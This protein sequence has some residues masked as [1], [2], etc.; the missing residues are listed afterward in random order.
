MIV[1]VFLLFM[2]MAFLSMVSSGQSAQDKEA[3]KK[4]VLAFQDDFNDGQ[5][6]MALAYTTKDWKHINPLGGIDRGRD[7][8]L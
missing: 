3:V 6:K 8:V 7:S 5:F 1:K 2:I 4:V